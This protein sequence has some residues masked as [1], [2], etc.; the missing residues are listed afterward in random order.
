MNWNSIKKIE[1]NIEGQDIE[2]YK[3]FAVLFYNSKLYLSVRNDSVT[4]NIKKIA[5]DGEESPKD[6]ES[7]S[8]NKKEAKEKLVAP[9]SGKYIIL[10]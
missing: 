6:S 9:V 1:N 3:T 5:S 8:D 7:P 4:P 10:K 2:A